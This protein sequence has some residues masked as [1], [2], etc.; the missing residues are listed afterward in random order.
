MPESR[1][2]S[3]QNQETSTRIVAGQSAAKRPLG[4]KIGVDAR[5]YRRQRIIGC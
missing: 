3:P 2:K 5:H 1:D 4:L